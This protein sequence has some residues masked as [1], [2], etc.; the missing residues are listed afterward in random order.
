MAEL[1][2]IGKYEIRRE[3]GRGA[4]GVVYEGYDPMIKRIVALKTI[5]ADE[6]ISADTKRKEV[7][8]VSKEKMA[9]SDLEQSSLEANSSTKSARAKLAAAQDRVNQIRA[10]VRS[11][12]DSDSEIKSSL[13]TMRAAADATEAAG[14]KMQRIREKIAADTNK[15]GRELQQVKQAE[16]ADKANDNQNKNVKKPNNKGK[17]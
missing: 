1:S 11:L 14:Q 10:K 8:Q 4:M 15:L 16:A 7:G 2:R 17:R 12:I 6:Q 5:R 9:A 13:Q 3:L